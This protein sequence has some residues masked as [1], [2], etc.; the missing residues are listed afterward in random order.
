MS[1]LKLWRQAFVLS[2]LERRTGKRSTPWFT[3]FA[4]PSR[5]YEK[6]FSIHGSCFPHSRICSFYYEAASGGY[7]IAEELWLEQFA[8]DYNIFEQSA[9]QM[10]ETEVDVPDDKSTKAYAGV[11]LTPTFVDSARFVPTPMWLLWTLNKRV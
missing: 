4:V 2:D 5:A 11:G 3:N 10:A 6:L 9:C 1:T 8:A 7:R